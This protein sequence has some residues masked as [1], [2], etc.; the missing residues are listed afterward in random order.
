M[1][2]KR[3]TMILRSPKPFARALKGVVLVLAA[4][5]VLGGEGLEGRLGLPAHLRGEF[6]DS[7]GGQVEVVPGV[8]VVGR[9]L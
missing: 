8:G 7:V 3:T 2:A 4:L 6:D 9:Y 1:T 5:A